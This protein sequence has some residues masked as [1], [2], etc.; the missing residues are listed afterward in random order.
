MPE[1]YILKVLTPLHVGSGEKIFPMEFVCDMASNKITVV[2][3]DA[4]FQANE[5]VL[6]VLTR[7][8]G[9][10]DFN[11]NREYFSSAVKYP[12][13]S[14]GSENGATQT[15]RQKLNNGSA[16]IQAFIREAGRVYIPG[17]S[18]KGALRALISQ[19]WLKRNQELLK[20]YE[21]KTQEAL[22]DPRRRRERISEKSDRVV[23][24]T[25]HTSPF[26]FFKAGDSEP[27][28]TDELL[29]IEAR[30]LNICDGRVK[31]MI[32]PGNNTDAPDRG[33]PSFLEV[34][35]PGTEVRGS[36]KLE[37]P[38]EFIQ[39]E[40][41]IN[42]TELLADFFA[43][44]K[45]AVHRHLTKEK[46]FFETYGLSAVSKKYDKLIEEHA[47]LGENEII[48]PMAW[49]TGYQAKTVSKLLSENVQ[50]TAKKFIL[51]PKYKEGI[52]FPK[53]RRVVLKNGQPDNVFG[54]VKLTVI[55]RGMG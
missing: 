14:Y 19:A 42:S 43:L 29:L 44:I 16:F 13:Y 53:T 15:L 46:R 41:R 54:W 52:M 55:Q 47:R 30:V 48:F 20:K 25:P 45:E 35:K 9:E 24:G 1:E 27:V 10:R 38:A 31:W 34:L 7:Q 36:W 11:L 8:M 2:D 49:G 26:R 22:S 28:S 33:A 12:R 40:G 39:R 4:F 6:P 21:L 32:S 51:G 50:E 23:F 18:V 3:M 5:A 17:S 37:E